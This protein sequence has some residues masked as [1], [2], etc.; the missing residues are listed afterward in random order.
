[1]N[2]G[3]P[4][5]GG[6]EGVLGIGVDLAEVPRFRGLDHRTVGHFLTSREIEE[7]FARE[8]P[9]PTLAGRF[10]AKEAVIKALGTAF[11]ASRLFYH[12]IVIDHLDSGAPQ[13]SVTGIDAG[14][15]QILLSISHTA[16]LAIAFAMVVQRDDRHG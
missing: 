4:D 6:A 2:I 15:I 13:A 3:S 5:Y 10:A 7:V 16:E 1:M 14:N 11:P 12:D 8:E 9:A